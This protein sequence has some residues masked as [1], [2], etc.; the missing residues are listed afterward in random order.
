MIRTVWLTL[1]CLTS[2]AVIAG[3][4]AIS[5]LTDKNGSKIVDRLSDGIST[6]PI[7]K[8]DKLELT[9]IDKPT[10]AEKLA[11]TT[12]KI[13]P[14][15]KEVPSATRAYAQRRLHT[16]HASH[17]HRKKFRRRDQI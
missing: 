16:H 14:Q 13:I 7:V 12:V 8:A 2:L 10:P 17:R 1:V 5:A 11:M 15:T 3:L 6:G 9:N 4:K